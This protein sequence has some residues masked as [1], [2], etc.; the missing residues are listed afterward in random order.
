MQNVKIKQLFRYL[1]I[2]KKNK[3]LGIIIVNKLILVNTVR[4]IKK[5]LNK[6]IEIRTPINKKELRYTT[7]F[8]Y[9]NSESA[10]NSII[11]INKEKKVVIKVPSS[12]KILHSEVIHCNVRK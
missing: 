4:L 2:D 12:I 8:E 6:L 1:E 5:R 7:F 10:K 11:F 3:K 9:R